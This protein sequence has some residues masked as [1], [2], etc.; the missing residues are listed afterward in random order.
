MVPDFEK[1]LAENALLLRELCG[2]RSATGD[3]F[4]RDVAREIGR[5]VIAEMRDASG[6]FWSTIAATSDGQPGRYYVWTE[7]DIR[8]ALGSALAAEFLE[9]YR[10]DPSG[11]PVLVGNPFAG[12]GSSREILVARRARRVRPAIDDRL[13][14]GANGLMIAGLSASGALLRRGAD[15]RRRAGRLRSSSSGPGRPD[16]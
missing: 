10:L 2:S 9:V 1:R 3:L 11:L 4:L 16:A 12:L 8:R 7:D 15:G 6:P 5:W 14:T 13:F